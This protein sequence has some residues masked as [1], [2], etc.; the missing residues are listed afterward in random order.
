M[1]PDVI[2]TYEQRQLL[3]KSHLDSHDAFIT[4]IPKVELHVHIEGTLAPSLR[5]ELSQRNGIPLTAG[6]SKTPLNSLAKV[7][8]AYT[9]I[10]GR[11]GAASAHGQTNMT[12][13]EA[14]YGGFELLKTE[15]DY[16]D[17]A[18]GYFER[19]AKMNVR[20]CEPFFDPQGH[21]RRGVGMDVV[22]R[23]LRRAQVEAEKRLN[24]SR[25]PSHWTNPNPRLEGGS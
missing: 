12:F 19:A 18:M 8:E 13:F 10:R 11:I 20:Y 5:W 3:R 1:P 21:T 24:V 22:M 7:Q 17:L 16:Y 4:G 25:Y 15:R 2:S 6:S 23:G 14:Y 9:Q